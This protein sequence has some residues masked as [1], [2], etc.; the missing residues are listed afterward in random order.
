MLNIYDVTFYID[1]AHTSDS[2]EYV[3]SWFLSNTQNSNKKKALMFNLTGDRDSK[4]LLKILLKCEF[5]DVI[6]VPNVAKLEP[7]AGNNCF[8]FFD[9]LKL[10]DFIVDNTNFNNPHNEQTIRC[11][12][13]KD[14][15][16]ELLK[17][18][19]MNYND[20]VFIYP[21]IWD[22]LKFFSSKEYNVLVTGSLHLIGSFLGLVK[23]NFN[24]EKNLNT[25]SI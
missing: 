21:T 25:D 13:H 19:N 22:G 3:A 16:I 17:E 15:W 20:N 23:P 6:F 5:Q 24:D 12:K 7:H 4:S 9:F 2:L 18:N 8:S 14:I 10:N 1:G 11:Q